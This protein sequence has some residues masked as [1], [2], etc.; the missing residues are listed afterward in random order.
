MTN[1]RQRF[2]ESRA[3]SADRWCLNLV[4]IETITSAAA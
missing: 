4:R 2:R 3:A 1:D